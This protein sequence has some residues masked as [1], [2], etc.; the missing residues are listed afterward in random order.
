M[1]QFSDGPCNY[2]K[3]PGKTPYRLTSTKIAGLTALQIGDRP[4]TFATGP[5]PEMFE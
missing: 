1:C 3:K 5:Q 4:F 2:S